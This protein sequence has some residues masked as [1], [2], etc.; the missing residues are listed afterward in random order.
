[1]LRYLEVIAQQRNVLLSVAQQPEGVGRVEQAF[2]IVGQELGAQHCADT[3]L[4]LLPVLCV[5]RFENK[6]DAFDVVQLIID[7]G[8]HLAVEL[9][10]TAQDTCVI[11]FR[12]RFQHLIIVLRQ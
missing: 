4:T 6:I 5:Q 12:Q 11:G 3:E 1:M 10:D 7:F 8:F 2:R 9:A